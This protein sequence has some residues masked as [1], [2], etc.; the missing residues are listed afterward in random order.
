MLLFL[1][2]APTGSITTPNEGQVDCVESNKRCA[3]KIVLHKPRHFKII[4]LFTVPNNAS[5]LYEPQNGLGIHKKELSVGKKKFK[6]KSLD[7]FNQLPGDKYCDAIS[8]HHFTPHSLPLQQGSWT[9]LK[10]KKIKPQNLWQNHYWGSS[11]SKWPS[12]SMRSKNLSF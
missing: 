10:E 9:F 5:W 7:T 8:L 11:V 12:R 4:F 2:F 1:I 6:E 3:F